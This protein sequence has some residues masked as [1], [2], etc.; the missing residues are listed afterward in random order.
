M[1]APDEDPL[2]PYQEPSPDAPEEP[3]RS[4]WRWLIATVLVLIVVCG[5]ALLVLHAWVGDGIDQY[6]ESVAREN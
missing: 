2:V 4:D 5:G 1:T 6:L 3:R